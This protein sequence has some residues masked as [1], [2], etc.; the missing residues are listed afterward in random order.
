MTAGPTRWR[1][2]P[3]ALLRRTGFPFELL[4]RL[5]DAE[6][7]EALRGCRRAQAELAALCGE[8]TESLFPGTVREQET[9]GAGPEIFKSLYRA[10]RSVVR[11]DCPPPPALAAL[12]TLGPRAADWTARIRAA[13]ERLA[14]ARAALTRAADL[15]LHRARARLWRTAASAEF[16][17][18][19]L[20]SNPGAYE[21]VLHRAGET[22]P[23]R[24][25]ARVRSE[26]GLLYAYLQRFC[27][28]NESVSFFGPVDAVE[29]SPGAVESLRLER[30]PGTLQARWLRA[31]H[32]TAEALGRRVAADPLIE[33]RL[34]LRLA[35][36]YALSADGRRLTGPTGRGVLLSEAS[37]AA[38]RACDTGLTLDQF[39]RRATAAEA[40]AARRLLERGVIRRGLTVPTATDDPLDRLRQEVAALPDAGGAVESWLAELD[41]FAAAV[42]AVARA[43]RQDRP[44]ALRAAEECFSEISGAE[45]RRAAGSMYADRLVVTEDCRGD[46]TEAALG[47]A[48]LDDIGDRLDLVLRLSASYSL[49]VAE[50]VA[51]RALAVYEELD[52]Q[53]GPL[54]PVPFLGFIAALDGRVDVDE[55]AGSRRVAAF[56]DRL[57]TLVRDRTGADGTAR[58]AERD[59]A[60]LLR[61]LPPGL[62]V[63]PDVFL[64]APDE[65]ALRERPPELV[66]GEIHHGTQVWTH[67]GALLPDQ[68][69]HA[70]E[71]VAL[72]EVDG[73]R[74]AALVHRRTQGKAFERDLPGR[75]IEVLGRSAKPEGQR[76]RAAEVAVVRSD[77]GSLRLRHP[78]LGEL[79]L[80]P[81]D[82]RAA[83]S[84]LF[85]PPPVVLPPLRSAGPAPRVR[86]G[87]ATV[88][89]RGWQ[90]PA[91]AFDALLTARQPA[92]A[93]LAADRLR[94]EHR[95]PGRVYARVAGERKPFYADFAEPLSLEHLAHMVR[96]AAGEGPVRLSETLPD[97]ADW[98]LA[99]GAGTYST[100]LRMT[101][102]TRPWHTTTHPG[103]R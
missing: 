40:A 76:V 24:R 71:L 63:S 100:E 20:L 59:L 13:D 61:P 48:L 12:E 37:V 28:K 60:P 74:P 69:R 91:A 73:R 54:A 96:S 44:A 16:R 23:A 6:A 32:W 55:L 56:V 21:R 88:W 72:L 51:E 97:P 5:T 7:A 98:W 27:A 52:G 103:S 102:C 19:V 47:G 15:A 82:P 45:S 2:A 53:V 90:L 34:P 81:R 64:A 68:D 58:L 42:E 35:A 94:S 14:G 99:D 46:V 39:T 80:R 29:I 3:L 17:E 22:V 70:K 26:E 50:E 43:G 38:V 77:D 101:Y 8:F 65:N 79:F 30:E 87:G 67:L 11:G 84:W 4:D 86:V 75:D 66:V 89:R 78:A 83:S 49:T 85:G 41:R 18:A 31:A 62:S 36:G 1:P 25:N 92:D 33:A 10:R 57:A 93:L 95:L 9:A